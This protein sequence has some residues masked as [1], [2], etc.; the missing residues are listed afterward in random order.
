[1]TATSSQ[2]S[3]GASPINGPRRLALVEPSSEQMLR[4]AF[5]LEDDLIDQLHRVSLTQKELRKRYATERGLLILPS[6][7]TI[8]KAI[9]K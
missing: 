5:D 9:G 4:D 1:M 8:R 3:G 6:L 7:E 2:R